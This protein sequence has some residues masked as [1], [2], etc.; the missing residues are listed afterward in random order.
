[1]D[2]STH[3]DIGVSAVGTPDSILQEV[4]LGEGV[5]DGG[6]DFFVEFSSARGEDIFLAESIESQF[7]SNAA[8]NALSLLNI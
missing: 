6:V 5:G 7:V 3:L 8:D 2:L 1:M 4:V